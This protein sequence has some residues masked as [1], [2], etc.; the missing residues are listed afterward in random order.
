MKQNRVLYVGSEQEAQ[1]LG[2][3]CSPFGMIPRKNRPDKWRIIVNLLTPEGR[4]VND[5]IDKE[6]ASLSYVSVDD[7]AAVMAKMD[8]RQ[9]YCNVPVH[10]TDRFLL[11]MS[12]QGKVYIDVALPFGLRSAPLIFTA[13]ADTMQWVVEQKGIGHVYHYVD[14][15]I[16]LV[17]P[18]ATECSQNSVLMHE[19]CKELGLP[20]EPD[21]D[22]GPATSISFLGME[23][24]SVAMEIRLPHK[25][26]SCMRS[27]GKAGRPVR[28]GSSSPS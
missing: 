28:R 12:W 1:R 24:D 4:S 19:L 21:K 20:A 17:A 22:E 15:F 18:N 23:L 6:L 3:H 14:D 2:I 13:I 9:A 10:P 27:A 8:I 7:V 11:G 5:G 26:L 25:K 16:T